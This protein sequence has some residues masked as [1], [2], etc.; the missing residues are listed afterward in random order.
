MFAP[1]IGNP[2]KLQL[3]TESNVLLDDATATGTMALTAQPGEAAH[4]KASISSGSGTIAFSGTDENSVSISETLTYAA[5][6]AF[7]TGY[8]F[9]SVT[10]LTTTLTAGAKI[11]VTAENDSGEPVNATTYGSYVDGTFYEMNTGNRIYQTLG[12]L[13]KVLYFVKLPKKWEALIDNTVKFK[14]VGRGDAVY[15][16]ATAIG[17]VYTPG[18]NIYAEIQFYAVQIRK[19]D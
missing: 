16:A 4:L 14:V 5:A 6:R 10:G 15:Q 17:R 9:K 11:T 19:D 8:L 7:I 2:Q 18:T 13:D 3:V 1:L 12:I